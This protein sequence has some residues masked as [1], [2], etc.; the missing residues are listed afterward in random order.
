MELVGVCPTNGAGIGLDRAEVEAQPGKNRGVSLVHAPVGLFLRRL[1]NMK[2]VGVFH[3]ELSGAHHAKARPN[4]VAEFGLDLE[5][6]DRQLF[7][8][9]DLA[10]GD[11]CDDFFVG[12]SK[13]EGALMS[14]FQSTQLG[15]VELPPARLFPQ[16]ARLNHRHAQL[17]RAGAL[18]FLSDNVLNFAQHAKPQ[19]HPVIDAG[20]DPADQPRPQ[21]E[22][23][24][25]DLSV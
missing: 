7:V 11:L 25:D 17:Q 16:L 15:P 23:M 20:G 5:Q 6:I 9:F 18:H 10:F 2:G 8:A 24:A 1:I 19:R 22:L 13:T 14:I 3:D 12:G 21:H 4:F